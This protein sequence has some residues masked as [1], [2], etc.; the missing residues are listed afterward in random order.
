M[1]TFLLTQESGNMKESILQNELAWGDVLL[2]GLRSVGGEQN[3]G[4]ANRGVTEAAAILTK[5]ERMCTTEVVCCEMSQL[6]RMYQE[7]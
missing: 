4:Q 6:L 7:T 1:R 3:S 5:D 2:G